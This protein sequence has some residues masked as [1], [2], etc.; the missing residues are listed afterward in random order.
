MNLLLLHFGCSTGD[1]VKPHGRGELGALFWVLLFSWPAARAVDL[2]SFGYNG[3][4]LAFAVANS[5]AVAAT[6]KDSEAETI[7]L[8]CE[9]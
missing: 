3:K 8:N 7:A 6:I 1:A 9:M 4:M 2:F 5:D